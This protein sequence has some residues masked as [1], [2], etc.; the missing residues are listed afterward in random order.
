MFRLQEL[1]SHAADEMEAP[2]KTNFVKSRF[3]ELTGRKQYKKVRRPSTTSELLEMALPPFAVRFA[4]RMFVFSFSN[5]GNF[6]RCGSVCQEA[7]ECGIGHPDFASL[8]FRNGCLVIRIRSLHE[9][10]L[11]RDPASLREMPWCRG[12]I[13]R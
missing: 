2:E 7:L 5:I 10:C 11:A 8:H 3:A 6:P 12:R 4:V 1:A 13:R 9:A